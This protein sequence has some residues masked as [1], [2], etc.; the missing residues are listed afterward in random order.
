[1]SETS[2][3][4]WVPCRKCGTTHWLHAE[5]PKDADEIRRAKRRELEVLW[6]NMLGDIRKL[7]DRFLCATNIEPNEVWIGPL[8]NDLA[9][10]E[11]ECQMDE[12]RVQR[13]SEIH[14]RIIFRDMSGAK[15]FGMTIRRQTVNGLRVGLSIS[16][17]DPDPKREKPKFTEEPSQP[18]E[19]NPTR[20]L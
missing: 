2:Y 11:L 18:W 1:M 3:A 12:G 10:A 13:T 14:N 4:G 5:C 16:P 7:R 8:E 9:A 20:G 19:K 15:V 6:A 17:E